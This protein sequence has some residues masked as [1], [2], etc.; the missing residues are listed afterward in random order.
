MTYDCQMSRTCTVTTHN[1]KYL[2]Y[3]RVFPDDSLPVFCH[4]G[5]LLPVPEV[6]EEEQEDQE[7]GVHGHRAHVQEG[8]QLAEGLAATPLHQLHRLKSRGRDIRKDG[9]HN[10][11]FPLDGRN[12]GDCM[13]GKDNRQKDTFFILCRESGQNSKIARTIINALFF[14]KTFLPIPHDIYCNRRDPK[15]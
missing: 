15:F 4:V 3:S 7:E 8:E 5:L 11:P 12:A 10:K 1:N 6:E 2:Y 9:V 14:V 13:N